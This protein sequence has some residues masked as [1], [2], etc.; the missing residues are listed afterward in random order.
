MNFKKLIILGCLPLF[1]LVL[2]H[3]FTVAEEVRRCIICGMDV[4]KYPHTRYW[5]KTTSGE[6]YVTCGTQCG[7]S[8]HLQLNEK[9]K[10]A[11]ATDLLSNRPIE[12]RKAFFVYKSSVI[13]DMSPGFIVFGV[14][15]NAEIFTK[16]FGGQVV[17]YEE[18]LALWK[19]QMQ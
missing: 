13:T 4:S 11:Q 19:K 9:F 8:L 7:L 2:V 18:A 16:G 10:S 17:T 3:S 5:V 14:R 12:A 6:E 15:K 1:L